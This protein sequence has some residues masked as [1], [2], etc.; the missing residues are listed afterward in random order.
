MAALEARLAASV[1]PEAR[2]G[3]L[4]AYLRSVVLHPQDDR[5][6]C[7]ALFVDTRRSCIGDARIGRGG[8]S[9][10][11][12]RMREIFGEALR[13]DARGIILAHNHPSGACRPSGCDI[14]ATH[15]LVAVAKALD[16]ELIDHLI[17]THE[18]VYSMRAGG[19]L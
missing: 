12:L 4:V 10:L 5:E 11:R 19:L 7:H 3:P 13:L 16:I 9:G 6:R 2:L 17:F 14:A 8:R 1:P 15:Q 18:A